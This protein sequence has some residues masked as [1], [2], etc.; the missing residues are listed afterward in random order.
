MSDVPHDPYRGRRVRAGGR[1]AGASIPPAG[2]EI[3]TEEDPERAAAVAAAERAGV[4]VR[5]NMKTETILRRI[6]EARQDQAEG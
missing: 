5:S 4:K 3:P 2:T 6:E 1:F